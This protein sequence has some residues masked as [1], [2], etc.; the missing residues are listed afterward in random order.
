MKYH[1]R[2]LNN[3]D[4]HIERREFYNLTRTE[5]LKTL[6]PDEEFL[7]YR[8]HVFFF[9]TPVKIE[10]WQKSGISTKTRKAER[11]NL[12]EQKRKK[13][14][15]SERVDLIPQLRDT[16]GSDIEFLNLFKI[17]EESNKEKSGWDW[18]GV[19]DWVINMY[20]GVFTQV[21]RVKQ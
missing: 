7:N 8:P 12:S 13:I 2:I 10:N 5:N 21:V 3:H 18:F 11:K 14:K 1:T 15:R 17:L 9:A 19:L 20:V 16:V 6:K 4:L